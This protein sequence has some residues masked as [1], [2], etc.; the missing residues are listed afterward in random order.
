MN[1]GNGT[2]EY[3]GQQ[4]SVKLERNSRGYNWSVRVVRREGETDAELLARLDGLNARL[5]QQYGGE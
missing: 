4:E 2:N 3:D 5:K 1:F